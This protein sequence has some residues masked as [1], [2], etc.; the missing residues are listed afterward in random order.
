M[1]KF[2][3]FRLDGFALAAA[4]TTIAAMPAMPTGTATKIKP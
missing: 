3:Q 2:F 4:L 1:F